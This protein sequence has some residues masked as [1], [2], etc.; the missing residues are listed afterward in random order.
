MNEIEKSSEGYFLCVLQC[1][2]IINHII[3]LNLLRASRHHR[4][5]RHEIVNMLQW[6]DKSIHE[7]ASEIITRRQTWSC[8]WFLWSIHR[9]IVFPFFFSF[10][11]LSSRWFTHRQRFS[12]FHNLLDCIFLQFAVQLQFC[13]PCEKFRRRKHCDLKLCN[14]SNLGF[15]LAIILGN[16]LWRR[17]TLI[18]EC[19]M[20]SVSLCI[21]S[22]SAAATHGLL[23]SLAF[24][25]FT[26][27]FLFIE[28]KW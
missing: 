28:W 4:R 9:I 13:S 25:F 15:S 26:D 23:Y 24:S 19:I 14:F 20:R 12:Q 2:K 8:K 17:L 16:F 1:P 18:R 5:R 6:A 10:I 22:L 21:R 27:S 11:F 7:H 3:R